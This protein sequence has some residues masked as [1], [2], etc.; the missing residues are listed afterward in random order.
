MVTAGVTSCGDTGLA[1]VERCSSTERGRSDRGVTGG[2]MAPMVCFCR[3]SWVSFAASHGDGRRG[4][5]RDAR[6][7]ILCSFC[8]GASATTNLGDARLERFEG[9]GLVLEI[10]SK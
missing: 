7:G 10:F 9:A 2:P 6:S 5:S 3:E 4:R 1:E 8:Q